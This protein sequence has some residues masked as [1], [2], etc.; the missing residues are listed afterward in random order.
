MGVPTGQ[1]IS[2]M[3][4]VRINHQPEGCMAHFDR[5]Q[6]FKHCAELSLSKY[7]EACESVTVHCTVM[8]HTD[9]KETQICE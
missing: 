5:E 9:M 6:D 8:Y 7:I 1:K 2:E 3:D 4:N